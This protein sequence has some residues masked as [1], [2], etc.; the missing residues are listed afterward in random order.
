VPNRSS[1]WRAIGRP[2][3]GAADLAL[4]ESPGSILTRGTEYGHESRT[5]PPLVNLLYAMAEEGADDWAAGP[6]GDVWA[7]LLR[8]RLDDART[9]TKQAQRNAGGVKDGVGGGRRNDGSSRLAYA[10]CR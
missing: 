2:R 5:G 6:G 4:A 7:G 1:A 10:P 3:I 8:D 9:S